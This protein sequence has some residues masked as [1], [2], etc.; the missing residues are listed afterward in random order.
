[1]LSSFRGI[2]EAFWECFCVQLPDKAFIDEPNEID[3]EQTQTT[4]TMSTPI[5]SKKMVGKD[6]AA[7][8]K[9]GGRSKNIGGK[10]GA[11]TGLNDWFIAIFGVAFVVSFSLNVMHL[12]M[13][14][15]NDD[16]NDIGGKGHSTKKEAARAALMRTLKD[17]RDSR[18]KRKRRMDELRAKKNSINQH[19]DPDELMDLEY[20]AHGAGSD[21]MKLAHLNCKPWGVS[22]DIAQ[23]M[24][25]WQDIPTDSSYVPPFYEINH[26]PGTER[27]YMTFEPDGGGW[28]NIRMAMES[29]IAIAVA[30][31]RTLVMPPQKKMYLLG[32]NNGG[33]KHHFNFVDF[34]PIER[35]AQDNKAFE[36]I[37]MQEYLEEE[38]MKGKLINKVRTYVIQWCFLQLFVPAM[39]WK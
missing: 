22:D 10:R 16:T 23:E 32:Q 1:M 30:T 14:P 8:T 2:R 29:T 17:F 18:E 3:P 20:G 28:N 6:R 9:T 33:Q 25:Y 34:F 13:S 27:R 26:R 21:A 4:A 37:S 35:M 24:V 7:K 19:E 36:V 12:T 38:G 31:G 11:G 5:V 39:R 15:A